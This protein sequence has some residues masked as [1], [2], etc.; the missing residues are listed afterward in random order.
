MESVWERKLTL[1]CSAVCMEEMRYFRV[2]KVAGI[3]SGLEALLTPP[4]RLASVEKKRCI[5]L[6][7]G[8]TG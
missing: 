4:S 2:R 6:A 1:Y 5:T 3:R 7:L 8:L